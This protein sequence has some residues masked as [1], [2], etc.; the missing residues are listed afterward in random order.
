MMIDINLILDP[1]ICT[2]VAEPFENI[3]VTIGVSVAV[4]V[5]GIGLVGVGICILVAILACP[6]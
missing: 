3:A 4:G 6:K 5:A 1:S 2:A